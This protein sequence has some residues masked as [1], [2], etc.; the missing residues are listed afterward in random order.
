[1]AMTYADVIVLKSPKGVDK[2]FTY[3]I[4]EH[5]QRRV[6]LGCRVWVPFGKS[7]Y[8][9]G[10]IW[11]L[12]DAPPAAESASGGVQ[13][14]PIKYVFDDEVHLSER[15]L[16]LAAF[17]RK[18][19]LCSYSEAVQ[20]FLPSGTGVHHIR[21]YRLNPERPDVDL[22]PA[23][24]AVVHLLES[25]VQ[26]ERVLCPDRDEKAKRAVLRRL[27]ALGVIDVLHSYAH[28]VTEKTEDWMRV[29]GDM[30]GYHSAIPEAHAAR[31]KLSE[32]CLTRSEFPR[33]EVQK[34]LHIAKG[35]FDGFVRAGVLER[36][37]RKVIR[38]PEWM[39]SADSKAQLVL[40][41]A[42]EKVYRDIIEGYD[43]GLHDDVLIHG[44][45][46]SGKTEIYAELIHTMLRRGKK[47]LV[48]VPEIALTPQMAARMASRFGEA[49]IA[50]IHSKISPGERYDQWRGIRR[51]DFDIVIGARSAVF[52]PSDEFGLIIMDE[53]HER[54]YISEKRPKYNTYD[55]ARARMRQSRG[56]LVSG[57]ATPSVSDYYEASQGKRHLVNLPGRYNR[58]SLPEIEVVDMRIELMEGNVA[59]L[60]RRL[61]E[62][63]ERRLERGEQTIILLNRTGHSTF[64]SCRACGFALT[65]PN[66]DVTLTYFKGQHSVQCNYC[67][68]KTFVPKVCPECGSPYFKFF[69]SG[70]EKLEEHLHQFFPSARIARMDRTT[71]GRKGSIEEIISKVE[72]E[73]TDIL[74]GTQMVAKGLDFKK[75]TLIGILSADLMLNL[76]HYM[77]SE[78]AY[79]LFT[80]VAGRAGRGELSGEVILQTYD[81]EHFV[82]N[83]W[84]YPEF[85]ERELAY[86]REMNYPPFSR[87]VTLVFASRDESEASEYAHRAYRFLKRS[88][89]KKNLQNMLDMFTPGPAL[90]KKIEHAYRWQVVIKVHPEAMDAMKALIRNIDR[91]MDSVRTCTLS[92]DLEALNMI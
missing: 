3:A 86:R 42:Q 10:I 69:G 36:F 66:C 85:F 67:G 43:S 49:R 34:E 84:G 19:A 39:Q 25:G 44:V 71:T 47:A 32:Y 80:Q 83:A 12:R 7:V 92:I 8:S 89:A 30:K 40:T 64:V 46:G 63:I 9:E 29:I 79:Q 14:K 65:C 48:L 75:V 26:E 33:I 82:L 27:M 2:P 31:K 73:Q 59:L 53:S 87:L 17:V 15:D 13:I 20:L 88:M 16:E 52:A 5:F 51:G 60:S 90:L 56:L 57:S 24:R 50:V 22:R 68:Y 11:Q 4:P 35:V 54:A 41:E 72:A 21:Q 77:A 62:A 61:Y 78:K 76:P 28:L 1:M 6:H 74:V 45:T 23:E 81:P 55:V 58:Q 18:D 37:E 91:R 38:H 70:T